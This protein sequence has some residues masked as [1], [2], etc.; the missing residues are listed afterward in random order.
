VIAPLFIVLIMKAFPWRTCFFIL[1]A[2]ILTSYVLLAQLLVRDPALKKQYPDNTRPVK[3]VGTRPPEQ[4]ISFRVV[5][6]TLAGTSLAALV[7]TAT[8]TPT[9]HQ[10][11]I[12]QIEQG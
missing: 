4:G 6:L 3:P 9:A 8:L 7:L 11:G 12:A 10:R 1:G 2:I 5:F